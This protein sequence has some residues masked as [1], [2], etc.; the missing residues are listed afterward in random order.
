MDEESFIIS[1]VLFLLEFQRH[2]DSCHHS[3]EFVDN[4]YSFIQA[5]LEGPQGK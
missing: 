2:E 4:Q 1:A 3:S 5:V